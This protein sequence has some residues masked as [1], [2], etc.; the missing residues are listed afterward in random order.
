[1]A[2]TVVILKDYPTLFLFPASTLIRLFLFLCYSFVETIFKMKLNTPIAKYMDT[3]TFNIA[4][5]I[6]HK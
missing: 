3:L 1:M 5:T 4:R 6:N 2:K